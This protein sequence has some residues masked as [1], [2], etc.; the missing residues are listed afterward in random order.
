LHWPNNA[1]L[2]GFSVR[3]GD[4]NAETANIPVLRKAFEF[5]REFLAIEGKTSAGEFLANWLRKPEGQLLPIRWRLVKNSE[6]DSTH[7]LRRAV[8]LGATAN[9]R[10]THYSSNPV[11]A[12]RFSELGS[13]RSRKRAGRAL[14]IGQPAL[15]GEPHK[16]GIRSHAGLGPDEIVIILD[17]LHAEIEV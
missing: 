1:Q 3:S 11:S 12:S 10:T 17:G 14:Q 8:K 7:R 2:A 15:S 16:L 4:G 13:D 6:L 5:P 9:Y